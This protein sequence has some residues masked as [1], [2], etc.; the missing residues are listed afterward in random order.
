MGS[1]YLDGSL[2]IAIVFCAE[3]IERA[4]ADRYGSF[5]NSFKMATLDLKNADRV[6]SS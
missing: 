4:V 1:S 5:I 6:W 2:A 3:R